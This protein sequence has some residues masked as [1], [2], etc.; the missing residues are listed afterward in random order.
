MEPLSFRIAGRIY[1]QESGLG[2]PGLIVRAYDK[3]LLFDDLL[4][5]ALTDSDGKF[6]LVYTGADFR[7]LF[8]RKPDIYLAIYAPPSRF[9]VDTRDAIRW[10]AGK[11]ETFELGIARKLLGDQ[12]PVRPDNQ[13]ETGIALP[14]GFLKIEKRGGFDVPRL[15][16]F[17]TTGAPGAPAVPIQM[18]Y[19]ALPLGG[20]VLEFEV[21]PGEAVRMEASTPLPAQE[22]FPDVGTD[23]ETGGGFSIDNVHF[24]MTPLDPRYFEGKARYPAALAELVRVEEIGP[25]QMAAVEVRPVQY[26]PST[27]SYYFYPQL[28]YRLTFD[29]QKAKRVAA[30]RREAKVKIGELYAEHLNYFLQSDLVASASDIFWPGFFFLEDTAHIIITD[31]YLWPESIEVDGSTRPPMFSERGAALSGDLV[32]EFQRL[33]SWRTSHGTRSRVITISEIVGGTYGDFTEGGFARDLGEVIRN[34]LKYAHANLDTIYALL[35]GD[36]NV[37]PMRRMAGAGGYHTFGVM[38]TTDNPPP[39]ARNHF[40]AGRAACKLHPDFTPSVNEP[41]ST[42]HGGVRIPYN[43]EAG[44]GNLGWYY[45]SEA[46]FNTR[47]EGFARRPTSQPT[48]YIIVEGPSTVIND[49]YYWVRDVNSIPSDFYYASL[50]GPRYSVPGKHDFDDNNNGLYGQVHWVESLGREESLDG[51]DFYSDVWVG[52]APVESAAEAAAF[53]DKVITYEDLRSPG[54]PSVAVDV[55]YL[56]KVLYSSDY[57][58]RE[59]QSRQNDTTIPPGEGNFTHANGTTLSKIHTRFD[60]TLVSGNLSHRLVGRSGT[61]Q[62]VLPYNLAA[63]ASNAGWY[64]T[65]SNTFS[66]QSATPTRF[67]KLVGPEGVIN[68]DSFFWD[69]A[70]LELAASEKETLRGM[71]NG[72]F[73]A[74]NNVQR[75]YSDYFDLTAPPSLVPLD[76]S[77]VRAAINTGQH[78]VSL[79]GHGWWGGCCA[80]DVASNPDFSNNRQ[81]F[82]AFADSCSTGRPDGVDS[83]GE[84]SVIDP[85]GGAV[86]YVGNTR[87]SWIGVGDNYEQFFWCMLEADGRVGPAAGMRLATDGVRSLWTF[88]AQTLYGDPAM[89]V[90]DHVP[91]VLVIKHP[92]V[93][94]IKDFLPFEAMV[95]GKPLREARVTLTGG[96][97]EVFQSKKTGPEGKA[98]FN[99]PDSAGQLE[100]LQVTVW[101]REGQLYHGVIRNG[102]VE[103]E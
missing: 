98:S 44:P 30:E 49:D 42:Y 35:G 99:L 29:L 11:D 31:N 92:K 2:V 17:S 71:M 38:R 22:P 7:D 15:P 91:P 20:D 64:F 39:A 93:Y 53:V 25:L 8:E 56:R 55:N 54:T 80:V 85:D 88:Y 67:V 101:S 66:T 33:A 52:R 45:T 58:G 73:P 23:K 87:Y 81:Y 94:Q 10:N 18:R 34:F 65:T 16:G 84:K 100:E 79:T 24:K 6:E 89:R 74:F 57:W 75:H 97:G 63:N 3:D 70:G 59:W 40:L 27:R 48:Q 50:V 103:L 68:Q 46:H 77:V 9:L 14:K 82:I 1:E 26:D 72:W 62:V 60:L 21:I 78:F 90:W 69:P 102:E 13:V 96:N 12:S 47:N 61:S 32:A 41:L 4:G 43:R 86:A 37:V 5:N 95:D 76:Q 83:L 36:V 28:K 51:V 19:V